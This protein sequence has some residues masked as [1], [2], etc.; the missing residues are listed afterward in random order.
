MRIERNTLLGLLAIA[1]ILRAYAAVNM[2][3]ANADEML[4][5]LLSIGTLT[6]PWQRLSTLFHGPIYFYLTDLSY[7]LF[8]VNF[9]AARFFAVLFSAFSVL[10]VYLIAKELFDAKIG[11]IAGAIFAFS[12]AQI[13]FGSLGL[14]DIPATALS[15][16]S[17]LFLFRWHKRGERRE[18]LFSL[19][20]YA[21]AVTVKISQLFLS[22]VFLL[23]L[24]HG[25]LQ[26]KYMNPRDYVFAA[27]IFVMLIL[28][29]PIY[30]YLL[31]SDKGLADFHIS[32]AFSLNSALEYF[33]GQNIAGIDDAYFNISYFN[34]VGPHLFTLFFEYLSIPLLLFF[35]IGSIE[36]AKKRSITDIALLAWFLVPIF[37]Y[38][39]YVFHAYYLAVLMPPIAIIASV[40]LQAVGSYFSRFTNTKVL[41]SAFLFILIFWEVAMLLPHISGKST[42]YQLQEDIQ[43]LPDNATVV[44]DDTIWTG[45]TLWMGAT[46]GKKVMSLSE[47]SQGQQEFVS[48]GLK[49][50]ILDIYAVSCVPGNCG[51]SNV[52]PGAQDNSERLKTDL[53]NYGTKIAEIYGAEGPEY[54]VYKMRVTASPFGRISMRFVGY[55]IGH[56]ERS[57]DVYDAKWP[58]GVIMNV[59]AH[60]SLW[61]DILVALSLPLVVLLLFWKEK[62]A[63]E[64]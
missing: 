14:L 11:V 2:P 17:I 20:I 7:L 43:R 41:V 63:I 48:Q 8:G 3:Q 40:G 52:E 22:P 51:W 44:M 55:V 18:L 33:R 23:I 4:Y 12:A 46:S 53:H 9:F 5:S 25:I 57:I 47:F 15:M 61:V 19:G 13:Y 21:V 32:R 26:K 35:V 36:I 27:L 39:F 16:L 62:I 31:F 29:V 64:L 6:S 24:G 50:G 56:P 58:M 54:E 60:L 59:V 30:N 45:T 42:I 28:P 1:F 34:T 38:L 37:S 49:P 10:L